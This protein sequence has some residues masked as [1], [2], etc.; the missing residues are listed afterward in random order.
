MPPFKT[1]PTPQ[2]CLT[3]GSERIG[4][5]AMSA[6]RAVVQRR[7]WP[8]DSDADLIAAIHRLDAEAH[9]KLTLTAGFVGARAGANLA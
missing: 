9:G 2:D 7:D 1:A 6:V 8:G 4:N 5:A 3:A